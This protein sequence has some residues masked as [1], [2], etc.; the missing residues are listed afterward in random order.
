MNDNDAKKFA[1]YIEDVNE[2][3]ILN[4]VERKTDHLATKVGLAETK[5]DI[6]KWMFIFWI[7][8]LFALFGFMMYFIKS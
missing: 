5:S 3:E 7:G 6:I 2:K 1:A 8:Q 4:T